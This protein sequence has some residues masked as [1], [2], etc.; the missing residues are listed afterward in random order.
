MAAA[1]LKQSRVTILLS[2][3]AAAILLAGILIA[4]A[5]GI[6]GGIEFTVISQR[7]DEV[8]QAIEQAQLLGAEGNA[9]SSLTSEQ[10]KYITSLT[11]NKGVDSTPVPS[12]EL[13]NED[14]ITMYRSANFDICVG[15]GLNNL[16]NMYWQ[17]SNTNVIAGF[18]KGSRTWLGYTDDVCRYPIIVGTGTTVIT[19][20]TFDGSRH[21][22]IMVTVID[23]PEEQWKYEILTLV[24]QERVKNGLEKLTWGDACADAAQTRARELVDKY[25]HTRPDGREWNTACQ[26]PEDGKL[27]FEGENLMAGNSAVSPE[28]TVAA[29]MNSEAHKANILNP[30]FT[31]L[32]VG[33]HYDPNSQYKLYWSQY[34]SNF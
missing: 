29:W 10:Q 4:G 7:S 13:W 9:G 21:D 6:N 22:S 23:I 18:Y 27:Y 15:G 28:S 17:T 16:G 11:A 12:T 1:S 33:F 26:E 32:S 25:A 20:G 34:F 3:N 30:N 24:N 2:I 19:A 8:N 31:K 5:I 14:S